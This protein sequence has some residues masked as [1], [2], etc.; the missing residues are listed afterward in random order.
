MGKTNPP[1][2]NRYED[3]VSQQKTFADTEQSWSIDVS[4]IDQST[5]DLSVKN[6]NK[7]SR[8]NT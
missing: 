3:F 6:P 1:N 4:D 2:D 7:D 8:G 5:Y